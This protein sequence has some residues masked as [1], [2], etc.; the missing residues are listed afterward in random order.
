VGP[1]AAAAEDYE[2][3]RSQVLGQALGREARRQVA[4]PATGPAAGVE[5]ERVG[6]RGRDL[7]VGGGD[8]VVGRAGGFGHGQGLLAAPPL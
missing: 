1:G 5:A 6:Q 3:G 7:L 8:E 2:A 4:A